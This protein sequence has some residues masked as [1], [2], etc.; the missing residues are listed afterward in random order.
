VKLAYVL[1]EEGAKLKEQSSKLMTRCLLNHMRAVAILILAVLCSVSLVAAEGNDFL[2]L[3]ILVSAERQRI[4]HDPLPNCELYTATRLGL[5]P[6]RVGDLLDGDY[7]Q[8]SIYVIRVFQSGDANEVV[9]FNDVDHIVAARDFALIFNPDNES[10]AFL[11]ART[12]EN[13][14]GNS[15]SSHSSATFICRIEDIDRS[16]ESGNSLR[17][18]LENLSNLGDSNVDAIL[19]RTAH[20]QLHQ[21]REVNSES[22]NSD[23]L[24]ETGQSFI[25][26]ERLALDDLL[27]G[28]QALK[29]EKVDCSESGIFVVYALGRIL[30]SG[31]NLQVDAVHFVRERMFAANVYPSLLP[32]ALREEVENSVDAD[33]YW[34]IP[35][36]VVCNEEID[37][38]DFGIESRRG[39]PSVVDRSELTNLRYGYVAALHRIARE[40]CMK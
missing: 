32:N 12:L 28:E 39:R 21:R 6:S 34:C 17:S 29:A 30:D 14:S 2:N 16:T 5:D 1:S 7:S 10:N 23:D 33:R 24:I 38:G 36:R 15:S 31:G 20:L 40:E 3:K 19:I 26:T 22:S 37:F 27:P 25:W 4:M 35:K 9:S 18:N 11:L 8:L 13:I